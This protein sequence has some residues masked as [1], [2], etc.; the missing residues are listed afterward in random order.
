MQVQPSR[1]A[2]SLR[3][4]ESNATRLTDHLGS[5]ELK[6]PGPKYAQPVILAVLA[7]GVLIEAHEFSEAGHHGIA[8]RGRL[9]DG[10]ECLML[11]HQ[12]SLQL[13]CRVVK[14]EDVKQRY[15]IGFRY[16][17]KQNEDDSGRTRERT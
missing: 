7:N 16:A 12:A 6:Q 2:I 17:S 8:I 14:T 4:A 13:L 5:F 11:V 9:A 15:P 10:S 1:R 3:L